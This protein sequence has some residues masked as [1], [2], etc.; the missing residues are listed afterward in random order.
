MCPTKTSG[1]EW[2]W[3]R[4]WKWLWELC[5]V[6]QS[7]RQPSITISCHLSPSGESLGDEET[8]NGNIGYWTTW[9]DVF[10]QFLSK[11]LFLQLR[12]KKIFFTHKRPISWSC[13]KFGY[14]QYVSNNG[15]AMT[16][17]VRVMMTL[18]RR[19][20]STA[21]FSSICNN[22]QERRQPCTDFRP[23]DKS[24]DIRYGCPIKLTSR[25]KA[26]KR[27]IKST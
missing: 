5:S 16:I 23:W 15:R 27:T 2:F 14:C 21:I 18:K 9:L 12:N 24:N 25:V 19:S 22:L 4:A 10:Y 8:E 1:Y 20:S 3:E 26:N 7:H 17:I 6:S 11:L 13:M